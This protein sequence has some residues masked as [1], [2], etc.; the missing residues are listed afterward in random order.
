M[1]VFS[2]IRNDPEKHISKIC[3]TPSPGTIPQICLCLCV[4]F[5]LMQP[6]NNK[7]LLRTEKRCQ[8]FWVMEFGIG[9]RDRG[10]SNLRKIR[11]VVKILNF[12]GPLKLTPFY[13][14]SIENRQFGGQKSK[15]SRGNFRGEFPPPPSSV[16][17]VLTPPYPGLRF[18]TFAHAKYGGFFGGKFVLSAHL[19]RKNSGFKIVTRFS[20][21]SSH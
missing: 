19:P 3:H 21:H 16:R 15:S 5:S 17:Y 18:G 8:K 4:F 7:L 6:A 20:R 12:E 13:R 14:D 9:D 1:C 10:G 11:G 2:P